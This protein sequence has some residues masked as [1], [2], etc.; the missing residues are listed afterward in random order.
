MLPFDLKVSEIIFLFFF[1][2]L[3]KLQIT[4]GL[5][6]ELHVSNYSDKPGTVNETVFYSIKQKFCKSYSKINYDNKLVNFKFFSAIF[7]NNIPS[8]YH[9]IFLNIT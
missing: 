9:Y 8:Y 7:K 6:S 1:F 5:L 2:K 4:A 3:A